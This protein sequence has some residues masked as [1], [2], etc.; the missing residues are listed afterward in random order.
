[1]DL[2]LAQVRAFVAV[3]DRRHF[4]RAAQDLNLTQQ[5]LSKRVTRLEA[6]LGPLLER[7]RDGVALTAAGERFLPAARH[8]LEVA[9]H[10]VAEVRQTPVAPLRVDVWGELPAMADRRPASDAPAP[11]RRRRGGGD[12]ARPTDEVWLPPGA[13]AW[14]E[15][16][17]A[18]QSGAGER[19]ATP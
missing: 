4:G 7:R 1:V 17:G 18:A 3:V 8:M 9:D 14:A 16:A 2:D 13:D 12:A 6:G 15:R 5:V 19:R 10:A 11:R